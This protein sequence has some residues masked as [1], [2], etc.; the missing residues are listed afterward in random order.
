M[1]ISTE[2][3]RAHGYQHRF[4]K[5]GHQGSLPMREM[6]TIISQYLTCPQCPHLDIKS[7][8]ASWFYT[9]ED[10]DVE[11]RTKPDPDPKRAS[12]LH[13]GALTLLAFTS[14]KFGVSYTY[15]HLGLMAHLC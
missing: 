14:V 8:F 10:R 5:I 15:A 3:A 7:N 2:A 4:G 11:S 9:S 13:A 1:Y 6:L 12:A